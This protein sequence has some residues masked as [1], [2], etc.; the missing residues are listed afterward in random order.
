MG[1]QQKAGRASARRTSRRDA[2]SGVG[3]RISDLATRVAGT[4]EKF[5][6]EIG[7]NPETVRKW[8]NERTVPNGRQLASIASRY[9]VST[10]ALL[11]LPGAEAGPSPNFYRPL[12]AELQASD[13]RFTLDT[14]RRAVGEPWEVWE[15]LLRESAARLVL[16]LQ[17]RG[18]VTRGAM[19]QN[20]EAF[21]ASILADFKPTGSPPP[22]W[23]AEWS[24]LE[25]RQRA[26]ASKRRREAIRA[27][28]AAATSPKQASLNSE[29]DG[30]ATG[31]KPKRAAAK[32]R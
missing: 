24:D 20:A 30:S 11:G 16:D 19:Q 14:V 23:P 8:K 25:R 1:N 2:L 21:V 22:W 6:R 5:A 31:S 27:D 3:Q 10:D 29:R 9:G 26:E 15:R 18:S 17:A 12:L 28:L 32:K 4:T 13:A 7:V